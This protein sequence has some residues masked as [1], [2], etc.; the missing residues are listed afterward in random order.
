MAM[1]GGRAGFVLLLAFATAAHAQIAPS[2]RRSDTATLSA[3]TRA[4][5]EDDTA[6]PGM[7][8]VLEG[9][10]LWRR[11]P[12]SGAPPCSGCHQEGSMKGVAARHPAW[13]QAA[14]RPVDLEGRIEECRTQRQKEAALP[15]D[16]PT[17][18]AL[19]AHVANQS[20]GLPIA[21]PDDP[22]LAPARERGRELF[23]RRMGQ[24]DLA[25]AQ[26]H[27]QNWGRKLAGATIPQGHPVG[28]P[29]YRLEWQGVGSL[30]RRLRGCLTGIRAE[31]FGPDAPEY[32]ELELY[33]SER[34]RGLAVE[35]P[36]VRP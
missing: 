31:P 2:E 11:A 8:A 9:E 21:P 13:S 12:A 25:C 16:H 3:E 23:R 1:G 15:P 29:I 32:V 14:G 6:N 20:R 28:Y 4:M 5:Q 10:E 33:L 26:C 19:A 27:D 17:R 7:F 35:T 36:A 24:L 18:L 30:Q 34:A 22:R